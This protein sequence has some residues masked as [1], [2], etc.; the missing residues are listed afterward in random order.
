MSEALEI[1]DTGDTVLDTAGRIKTVNGQDK[2]VQDLRVL[3]RSV[4]GSFP[5]DTSFGTEDLSG[6]HNPNTKLINSAIQAAILQH[7]GV[8]EVRDLQI[9]KDGRIANIALTV[10]LTDGASIDLEI[11]L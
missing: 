2:I 4:K 5:F 1:D 3:L 6:F 10:I 9:S 8:S 7:P 11:T